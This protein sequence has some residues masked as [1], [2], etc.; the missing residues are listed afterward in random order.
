MTEIRKVPASA[1]AE[2]LL[3][4]FALLRKA[5]LALG[6]LA[7]IWGGLSTLA[8]MTGQLW[9]SLSLA[10][11]GPILFGGL[12]YAAREVE[13]GRA[14]GPGHLVQGLH[15]R[16]VPRLLA[17]LLPQ[18]AAVII[19]VTM[20]FAMIG[21][22]QLQQL[23][24]VMEQMQTNPDPQ[25]AETLPA[26]RMFAWLLVALAVGLLASFFTFVAIPE[27]MFTDR[28]AIE[29]MVLSF[30]A[31]VRNLGALLVMILL[32]LI[33][34]MAISLAMQLVVIVLR[35]FIGVQ[36]AV[37]AGQVLLMIVVLPVMAGAVLHAWR[38]M[39]GGDGA[40]RA[41]EQSIDPGGFE[42]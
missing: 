27:V 13:Q 9:L 4:G 11:L 1:G 32:T 15:D 19:L 38:Q 36:P 40:D 33:A 3:G 41:P 12:V 16:K 21:A 2:W 8:S 34:M 31:C 42:A 17:M 23:A 26:G 39:L 14:A 25:L 28:P 24:L 5:P 37:I 35:L 18:L 29:S 6:L 7:L 30:R 22:E 20:L 10:L